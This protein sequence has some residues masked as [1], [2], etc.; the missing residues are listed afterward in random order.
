MQQKM[1]NLDRLFEKNKTKNNSTSL[2]SRLTNQEPDEVGVVLGKKVIKIHK[3]GE[4]AFIVFGDMSL[5]GY[6]Q[7]VCGLKLNNYNIT[8]V[9]L[10]RNDNEKEKARESSDLGQAAHFATYCDL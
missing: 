7:F 2:Q 3:T 1:T 5:H 8:M 9:A 10:H 6:R 4:S